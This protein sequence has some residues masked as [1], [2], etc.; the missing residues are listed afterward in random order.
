MFRRYGRQALLL[1]PLL[2]LP[3]L[4]WS[5]EKPHPSVMKTLTVLGTRTERP[6]DEIPR[7]VDVISDERTLH[8]QSG[9]L[10]NAITPLPN[11]S[12]TGSPRPSARASRSAVCPASVCY[13][14]ESE[15]DVGSEQEE[16]ALTTQLG[17]LWQT[18][19]WLSLYASY[20]EAFRAPSLAELYTTG[21]HFG[22]NCFVPNP[23]LKP[24]RAAN[25]EAGL[26]AGWNG[27][28]ATADRLATSAY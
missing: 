23:N 25:K 13:R 12:L 3:V 1:I 4:G 9:D 21:I 24:E 2:A 14:S 20:A 22:A 8:Q 10:G 26:R 27:L 15:D 19:D 11:V 5:D 7:S 18:T 17:M 16:S 6:S 28:F